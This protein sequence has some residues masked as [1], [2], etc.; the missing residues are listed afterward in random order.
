MKVFTY[1]SFGICLLLLSSY[2]LAANSACY[3]HLDKSFYCVGEDIHFNLYL[4]LDFKQHDVSVK[5]VLL[6]TKGD[7][8]A[9]FFRKNELSS[10][11][12]GRYRIPY[13]LSPE[14]YYLQF[15]SADVTTKSEVLFAEVA[16]PIYNFLENIIPTNAEKIDGPKPAADLESAGLSIEINMPDD[17]SSRADVNGRIQITN[18]NGQAVKSE[19]SVSVVNED[20]GGHS[21]L[22]GSS[23]VS[24][25][26]IPS[27]LAPN[28]ETQM[29]AKGRLIN[30][31]SQPIQANIVGAFSTLENRFLF[32]KSDENGVF[33]LDIPTFEGSKPVQMIGY[34]VD[35]ENITVDKTNNY[36]VQN[37][38]PFYF[39]DKIKEYL[40]LC[41]IRKKLEQ[42]F[43]VVD[44]VDPLEMTYDMNALK[45]DATYDIR[46]YEAFKTFAG[47]F[48][49]VLTPLRFR[50]KKD[51][52][53]A[54]MYDP[55]ERRAS[56]KYYQ[57]KPVF[58]VNGMVTRD[59]N[60]IAN[61]S[62][63]KIEKVDL[64]FS[65]KAL[66]DQFN[67]FG[68]FG[69]VRIIANDPSLKVPDSELED[70]LMV[71]GVDGDLP[72]S[73]SVDLP[74]GFPDLRP[75]VY[76]NSGLETS[77]TGEMSFE[78][79]QP[80]DEGTYTVVVVA[81]DEKGNIGTKKFTYSSK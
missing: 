76:W 15:M 66:R 40:E 34:H 52:F 19:I 18:A 23:I 58:I 2:Q 50:E 48:K 80:D 33:F 57:G 38:Q 37:P 42:H 71:H 72:A 1:L 5:V 55:T 81:R 67:A 45:P 51:I 21:V 53:E 70:I 14:M 6:D 39:N 68:R 78:Y 61:L 47:F 26:T 10:Q 30:A 9:T 29:Y 74:M 59:G 73:S 27:N 3:V 20:I 62:T 24:G 43:E 46:E 8:K 49:E 4:P 69:V 41:R 75:Q 35:H 64:F 28:L 32:T 31:D 56:K 65:P 36:T 54:Y 17:I 22:G 13:S 77:S 11:V 63:D 25:K 7:V 44:K 79:Q 12:S 60:Y 16:V